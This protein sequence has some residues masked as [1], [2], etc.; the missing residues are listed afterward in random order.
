VTGHGHKNKGNNVHVTFVGGLRTIDGLIPAMWQQLNSYVGFRLLLVL[1]KSIN[2]QL[3]L[4]VGQ[5]PRNP[6]ITQ[7]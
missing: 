6:F 3:L 4:V 2:C 5:P 1:K 7:Q